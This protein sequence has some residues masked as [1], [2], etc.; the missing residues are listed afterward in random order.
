[1]SRWVLN[2]SKD[3]DFTASLGNLLQGLTTL[4]IV[5]FSLDLTEIFYFPSC[6]CCLLSCHCTVKSVLCVPYILALVILQTTIRSPLSLHFWRLNRSISPLLRKPQSPNHF[7]ALRW[8]C[9]KMLMSFLSRLKIEQ[10]LVS[11]FSFNIMFD[12][13][14]LMISVFLEIAGC[15]VPHF[16]HISCSNTEHRMFP[17]PQLHL[18]YEF[19][20]S[21]NSFFYRWQCL[22]S[23]PVEGFSVLQ[24]P[25]PITSFTE[26]G[27]PLGSDVEVLKWKVNKEFSQ[28]FF[29]RT[30]AQ[31]RG[32]KTHLNSRS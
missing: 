6:V 15:F 19:L 26:S 30:L 5:F 2:T 3:E 17:A 25:F 14:L 9:S 1:M 11:H 29:S 8:F 22:T 32:D 24:S 28:I 20:H 13:P 31:P 7:M 16:F 23:A 4:M 27:M 12:F 21:E 18:S 10:S